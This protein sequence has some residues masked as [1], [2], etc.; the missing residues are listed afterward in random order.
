MRHLS[1]FVIAHLF[2]IFAFP[3][4]GTLD[5]TLTPGVGPN[6]SITESCLQPDGKIVLVGDFTTYQGVSRNHVTRVNSNGSLD[7]TFNVGTGALGPVFICASQQDGKVLIGGNFT[8]FNGTVINRIARLNN[9]GSIDATFNV[10]TGAAGGPVMAIA[11]QPDGKIIVAGN[12]VGFNGTPVE[13]VVR[14][15]ANGSVDA[16][17]N[18]TVDGPIKDI[19]LEN[20]GKIV[21]AGNFSTCNGTNRKSVA[22]F[23]ANGTLFTGFDPGIGPNNNMIR[24]VSVHSNGKVVVGGD[25]NLWNNYPTG[26]LTTLNADG[27]VDATFNIGDG[28]GNFVF[29]TAIQPDGKIIIGGM[30]NSLSGI[31]ANYITRINSNGSFDN[32][33]VPGTGADFEVYTSTLQPDGKV[34]IGGYFGSY[35]GVNRNYLARLSICGTLTVAA[36]VTNTTCFDET[37]G[38]INVTL[39]GGSDPYSY[40]WGSGITTEDRTGLAAGSYTLNVSDINNCVASATTITVSEP[41]LITHSFVDQSCNGT[42]SWNAQTYTLSGVYEQ[43]LTSISGCDSLVTLHLTIGTP[44]SFSITASACDSYTLNNQTYTSSGTYF[45]TLQNASGCDSILT[46]IVNIL[47]SPNVTVTQQNEITLQANAPGIITYQWIDCTTNQQIVGA[48]SATFTANQNGLYAVEVTDSNCTTLSNCTVINQVEL[49]ENESTLLNI[50]PNPT[51]GSFTILWNTPA[52]RTI[53]VFDM[54]GKTILFQA[55]SNQESLNLDVNEPNGIFLIEV[56]TGSK[57]EYYKV[58]K[59]N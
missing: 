54:V 20:D 43:T 25:F 27:T 30:F 32:T 6:Y 23:N 31:P 8:S 2:C 19:A 39:S 16:S 10:G 45:Q 50:Y 22:K 49:Y 41:A 42:Y 59:D 28:F 4:A 3:Q 36:S 33:W 11:V 29:T 18:V 15:N 14:L 17:F 51:S 34:I 40:D 13:R 1:I 55:T 7:L 38:S 57:M 46:V 56:K 48:T 5:P 52:D 12:F 35:N 24:S 21:L 37:D 9:D 53:R 44:T 47:E 58:V 26:Y